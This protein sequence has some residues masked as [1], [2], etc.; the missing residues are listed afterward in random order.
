MT[1]G[2]LTWCS[3]NGSVVRLFLAML[4]SAHIN[5]ATSCMTSCVLVRVRLPS[6]SPTFFLSFLLACLRS[7]QQL[8]DECDVVGASLDASD[9]LLACHIIIDLAAAS[10]RARDGRARCAS[11]SCVGCGQVVLFQFA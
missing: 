3:R 7:A 5:H 9:W 10:I 11:W 8:R 4:L 1:V 6:T 2:V